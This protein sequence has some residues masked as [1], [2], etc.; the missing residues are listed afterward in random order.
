MKRIYKSLL[1]ASVIASTVACSDLLDTEPRQS[2]SVDVALS[3]PDVLEPLLIDVY[4]SYRGSG[5]MGSNLLVLPEVMADNFTRNQNRGT[6]A[7]QYENRFRAHMGV[8]ANY[9]SMLHLNIVIEG[10]EALPDQIVGEAFAFRAL[11]YL[12][13]N[14]IY[15]YFPTAIVEG[16]DFGGVPLVREA[17]LSIEDVTF[18]PRAPI[19]DVYDA[20]FDDVDEAISL[21]NNSGT[22]ARITQAGA[23]AIGARAALYAGRWEKAIEYAEAA[24]ASG[25]GQLSTRASYVDD[26]YEPVHREAI[27]YFEFQTQENQGPNT[28]PMSIYVSSGTRNVPDYIGNGDFTPAQQVIDLLEPTDVRAGLFIPVDI[29]QRPNPIGTIELHKYN[30]NTGDPNRDNITVFRVSEMY[31]ILAEA[32]AQLGNTAMAHQNLNILKKR[33]LGPEYEATATGQD[34]IMEILTERRLELIGE[35][36]R[37]FDLKRYGMDI[38]KSAVDLIGEVISFTDERILAPLPTGDLEINPNL[39]QNFGY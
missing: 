29:A 32:Y 10:R 12:H 26:W 19:N 11:H 38:D 27:W 13:L 2:I 1:A 20:I 28:S 8:W 14:A 34:L 25:I 24:I 18:P 9:S 36:H 4:G 31:L 23:Q 16:R 30:G 15:A 3:S 17:I 39:V 21:M 35:G 5:R 37:F 6:F 7:A 22:R 33:S